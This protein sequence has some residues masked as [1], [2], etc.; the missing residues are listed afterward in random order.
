MPSPLGESRLT[1]QQIKRRLNNRVMHLVRLDW[2]KAAVGMEFEGNDV[3]FKIRLTSL[4][5]FSGAP[6][7]SVPREPIGRSL[8]RRNS[9]AS[10][11]KASCS[12]STNESTSSLVA[13]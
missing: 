9:S 1:V 8:V 11:L 4:R 13:S 3:G 2:Y 10:F 5:N 7:T 6:T 12:A